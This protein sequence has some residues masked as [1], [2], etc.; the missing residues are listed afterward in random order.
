MLRAR[1]VWLDTE[2]T[3]KMATG[4]YVP[5]RAGVLTV[6]EVYESWSASRGHIS[7]KTAATRKS[8]WHS[9]VEPQWGFCRVCRCEDGSGTRVG[10]QTEG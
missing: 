8:A 7:A 6:A 9:R 1:H 10:R 5:L 4:T 2:I 3:A